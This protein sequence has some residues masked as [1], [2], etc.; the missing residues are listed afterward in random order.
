MGGR[1]S[2]T[3]NLNVT[4][5]FSNLTR[6]QHY[7]RHGAEFHAK[8]AIDYEELAAKF[9]SRKNEPSVDSFVSRDGFT[10]MYEKISNTFLI[11]KQ[12]GELVTFFRP[13]SANYWIMQRIKYG[14]P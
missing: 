10:F 5:R 1:G 9:V 4:N 8:S 11:H 13:T 12:S 2:S 7:E 3:V 6:D 14:T